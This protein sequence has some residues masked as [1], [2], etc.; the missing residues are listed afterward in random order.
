MSSKSSANHDASRHRPVG[1]MQALLRAYAAWVTSHP[2]WVLLG[3]VLFAAALSAGMA[4]LTFRSD[5]RVFFAQTNPDLLA[6]D[7]FEATYGRDDTLVFVVGARD[8]DLFTAKRLA[9]INELTD[10]AWK[11]PDVKRVDSLTNFQRALAVG[12]DIQIDQL[13]RSGDRLSDQDAA[14]LK[15]EALKEPLLVGRML[16]GDARLGL[17]AV[18]FRFDPKTVSDQTLTAMTAGKKL[19]EDFAKRHPDLEVGLSGSIALDHAFV[20][21]STFDSSVLLPAMVLVLLGIIVF[22]LRSAAGALAT[23]CVITLGTLSALGTAALLGVPLSSPSVIAPN[24]I[25][26]IACCDCIHLCSGMMRLRREG[27]SRRDAVREVLTECW[28]PVTLTTITTSIGFL[29]LVFSAV[30]PFAHL[31]IIVALG[32]VLTWALTVTFLPALLC[33]LPWKGSAKTLPAETLSIRVAG[34]VMKRP[35]QVLAVVVVAAATLSAFAFTNRLDD[36]YVRYF[37]DSYSFRQATDRLNQELGGFYTLEFSLDAGEADG[38]A[39][40]DYLLQVDRFAQWLRTQPGVTHVHGLPDIMK[41]VNRAMNGGDQSQYRLPESRDTSAQY[42]ALYE[43]SLPF[44]TDLKNQLTADKRSSRLSVNLDDMSTAAM[45]DLQAR[46]QAWAE[47]NTPLIAASARGT[48]TSLLFA[49]IGNRNIQEMLKG[50]FSGVLVVW[51]IFL[52]AFRSIGLSIIGTIANFVPSLATLGAWALVN[53]EVG[54]AVATVASVTFGVVVDDTIHMLTT[55]S[56]LRREEGL[57]AEAAV[58]GAFEIVGPGMIA[59]TLA[60]SSG[61]AC[62]AF[63]GFQINAWMGLMA[64]VTILIAVLFDLLFIPSILLAFRGE[65]REPALPDGALAGEM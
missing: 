46:A 59:M 45:A 18:N 43:M 14:R 37:D 20:E 9:A 15:S 13:A 22:V 64:S 34:M 56:R 51:L 3:S 24:I 57:S 52:I 23:L 55:Y 38:I 32:S 30:P 49:H 31:G 36:R 19:V 7:K 4:Q 5:S 26:T 53:G 28:W 21:A 8:G 48:G 33:V 17:V 16:A 29:S 2:W 47:H 11:L 1:R 35:R 10:A 44:G 54:M 61:F 58:R 6:L 40:N 25:L 50:V 39:R 62:L 60:L 65:K 42:L 41:T 63:S 12:D 27:L